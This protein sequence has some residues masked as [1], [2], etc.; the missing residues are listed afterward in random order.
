MI[1][2]R[3]TTKQPAAAGAEAGTGTRAVPL[4]PSALLNAIA[5]C[6]TALVRAVD[7]GLVLADVLHML[8]AAAG[9]NRAYV[10]ERRTNAAGLAIDIEIHRWNGPRAPPLPSR[11]IFFERDA[12]K[13]GFAKW[14]EP[15]ARGEH[16]AGNIHDFEASVRDDLHGMG[17]RTILIVPIMVDAVWWGQIG[18]DNCESDRVWTPGEIDAVKTLAELIGSALN[19]KA[20]VAALANAV[21]IVDNSTTVLFRIG[22]TPDLPLLYISDNIRQSRTTAADLL[23]APTQWKRNISFYADD[24]PGLMAAIKTITDGTAITARQE[25]R[26]YRYDGSLVWYDFMMH[27]VFDGEGALIAIEGMAFDVTERKQAQAARALLAAIVNSSVD[28]IMAETQSGKIT[29]WNSGAERLFG[30]SAAEMIGQTRDRL[31]PDELGGEIAAKFALF[32]G[33]RGIAPFD[34][35][36]MTKSGARIHVSITMSPIYDVAAQMIGASLIFRDITQARRAAADLADR[37]SLLHAVTLGAAILAKAETLE[38]GMPEA[39]AFIGECLRADRVMILQ[40]QP[41]QIPRAIVCHQWVSPNTKAPDQNSFP[42]PEIAMAAFET[43]YDP[44]YADAVVTYQRATAS[45]P[46]RTLMESQ[47]VQS[48][49]LMAIFVSG[50]LWGNFAI[51]SCAVARTWTDGELAALKTFA[52]VTGAL[53]LRAQTRLALERSEGRFRVMSDVAQDGIITIDELARIG[54]WN[55]AAS[56]IFGWS[57]EEALGR[58]AHSMMVPQRDQQDVLRG[59]QQFGVTG[60]G[61]MVGRTQ[62]LLA[63]RKDGSEIPIE[64]SVASA[65]VEGQW[66]AIAIVRDITDRKRIQQRLVD[67]SRTDALTGIA[68]RRAFVD[69]LEQAIALANRVGEGF[70]VLYLDLDHFKDINDTMGHPVGDDLLRAVAQRL[71]STVRRSDTIARFGGDEFA[72][73]ATAVCEPDDA[74]RLAELI[75]DALRQPFTIGG[76]EIRCAT[77][78]GIAMFGAETANAEDLLSH[79]DIALYRAKSEERGSYRFFTDAMDL[80]V[81]TRVSMAAELRVAIQSGQLFLLYQPQVDMASGLVIGLEALVRWHHPQRGVVGPTAFIG[82]SEHSDLILALGHW[83]MQEAC[84]QVRAWIDAGIEPCIVAVNFSG[85][86]F[87]VPLKLERDIRALVSEAGLTPNRFEIELTESVLMKVSQA[88]NDMLIRLRGYG[89]RLAIDDFG[90]GYSSLD[91]LRQFPVDRIKIAQEFII[92]LGAAAGN[93]TIVKA[94]IGLAQALGIE[95]IAEGVETIE[96]CDLLQ[97]WGCP[98]AQGFHFSQPL[99]ADATTALLRGDRILSGAGHPAA[100]R[101]K[102]PP[103]RPAR[104]RRPA[105]DKPAAAAE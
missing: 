37:D 80:E 94:T 66:H 61:K 3:A 7:P 75:V 62:E 67:M 45:G 41:E 70:A 78:V 82:L 100:H 22:V 73:I 35:E 50:T 102:L 1:R 39:L 99:T 54:H 59:M 16:V 57:A 103:S 24:L 32:T 38:A 27:A 68:N 71:R 30:Y 64:I 88:N 90:T 36:L 52:D 15:L 63:V 34:S 105:R 84:R 74:A 101:A 98:Q 56:R 48:C 20:Q 6:A 2:R 55:R 10:F 97:G 29:S 79:A 26:A 89:F 25:C 23:K 69:A 9:A 47:G 31:I 33:G 93:R 104:P 43:W 49:L 83:V 13:A 96:E 86:Q 17:V 28:G 92:H 8:G 72:V 51:Y 5:R 53:I 81:R 65:R 11:Q 87:K 42:A 46:V 60:D 18:L 14:L 44:L 21:Q 91:Y 40:L 12:Q 76:R 85:E 19:R 77:S 58:T 4:R 95:I